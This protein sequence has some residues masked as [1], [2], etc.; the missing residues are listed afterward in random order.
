MT[1][2]A[3]KQ[4]FSPYVLG[5][6][7]MDSF[8]FSPFTFLQNKDGRE[9]HFVIR[10]ERNHS[11]PLATEISSTFAESV[12]D[13]NVLP[14]ELA[15]LGPTRDLSQYHFILESNGRSHATICSQFELLQSLIISCAYEEG[16]MAKI[17]TRVGLEVFGE[18]IHIEKGVTLL[19]IAGDCLASVDINL[20]ASSELKLFFTLESPA[21]LSRSLYV[22]PV[23]LLESSPEQVRGH[24]VSSIS[25]G[26]QIHNNNQIFK[27]ER[28]A[29]SDLKVSRLT[30][31]PYKQRNTNVSLY[32]DK[33]LGNKETP[34]P[35]HLAA[36]LSCEVGDLGHLS[37]TENRFRCTLEQI[38]VNPTNS[39]TVNYLV[40]MTPRSGST[41][42]SE[43]LASLGIGCPTE[44]TTGFFY[45]LLSHLESV[46]RSV[47]YIKYVLDLFR[48]QNSRISGIQI[49]PDR[50][51]HTW[52]DSLATVIDKYIYFFRRSVSKQALSM[53]LAV[54]H[55]LWF[56]YDPT[57][58]NNALERLTVDE[59][60]DQ[61]ARIIRM[62]FY[63]LGHF[64]L[65]REQSLILTNEQHLQ[66]FDDYIPL[67]QDH[68][69]K[70]SV[71]A[72]G[73]PAFSSAKSA[74]PHQ[75]TQAV[76]GRDVKLSREKL[77]YFLDRLEI[78]DLDDAM[79]LAGDR[80]PNE[81]VS[82]YHQVFTI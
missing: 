61:L 65:N 47:P 35:V 44:L 82:L 5:S 23:R 1:L 17:W 25:F 38:S 31:Q 54:H 80:Q 28:S 81:L 12:V 72:G 3:P 48:D 7:L 22:K 13:T 18:K 27:L 56:S 8:S 58:Y 32:Y 6:S 19:T 43:K 11:S 59:F 37:S 64:L 39:Q 14:G 36:M 9:A 68:L 71:S 57:E 79:A 33:L 2:D 51:S 4:F 46:D 52:R 66:S 63:C 49:D 77:D 53:S 60:K 50:L 74:L 73:G 70:C 76:S 41:A 24:R 21:A 55:G 26:K 69:G 10:F 67:I 78:K 75:P 16:V 34:N 45:N 62:N 20:S 30:Y 40:V 29:L 42:L 15:L